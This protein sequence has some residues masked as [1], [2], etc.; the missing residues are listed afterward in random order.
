MMKSFYDSLEF[1][2]VTCEVSELTHT[3]V[4]KNL[5]EGVRVFND[6]QKLAHELATLNEMISLAER[7]GEL[8]LANSDNLTRVIS[9][10]EKFKILTVYDLEKVAQDVILIKHIQEYF[11]KVEADY[12]LLKKRFEEF[13][14]LSSLENL[15]HSV[16]SPNL[17]IYDT[18]SQE[19]NRIRRQLHNLEDELIVKARNIA[20][21]YSDYLQEQTATIRN[22]HYVL[23]VKAMYKFKVD[24]IIHDTSDSGNSVFIEPSLIVELNNKIASLKLEEQDEITRILRQLTDAVL[25]KKEQVITNNNILGYLDFVNAKT[26]F[27]LNHNAI[28]A[29]VSENRIIELKQAR[30]PL[31]DKQKVVANDFCLN[32]TQHIMIISGPNAG[33]K[34]V[35]LKTVGLLVVMHQ[36]GFPIPVVSAEIP[37]FKRIYVD[38][39]DQQSLNDSLSTFSAHMANIIDMCKK[40]GMKD[41]VLIDELGTG[42]DPNEGEALAKSMLDYLHFKHAY[43]LISSHFSGVKTYALDK[44]Y[45]INASMVF[46]EQNFAPT[47]RLRLGMPGKSYGMEVA[48]R[49][50]LEEQIILN[51]QKYLKK[52]GQNAFT[53]SLSKLESL[54]SDY[55]RKV[56]SINE[57]EKGLKEKEESLRKQEESLKKRH[58][59]FMQSV[60]EDKDEL[61]S[62]AQAQIDEIMRN[63]KHEDLKLHEIIK[64]RKDLEELSS[65]EQVKVDE[66]VN[67]EVNDYV[68][69]KDMNLIGKIIRTKGDKYI[70]QTSLGNITAAKNELFLTRKP[71]EKNIKMTSVDRAI[72]S[73]SVPL[74]L[75]L[76][77]MHVEEALTILE[78]YLDD[79]VIKGYHQV[80]IIHGS[81]TGALRTAV[82]EYLR[83]QKF[84]ASFRLGGMGEGGVGATV[85]EIK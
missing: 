20:K 76:I 4:A 85:V 63:L 72:I 48:K 18:A 15:I 10:A 23:A 16:I 31:I 84:V 45:V 5:L 47:Y 33:G 77:G 13:Q 64:A 3:V 81:G 49:L 54:V 71:T 65:E 59:N 39:G 7:F 83:K 35:A 52:D 34:S 37:F 32:P 9:D 29:N 1:S 43:A 51:A 56:K 38:I 22:G 30:H 66:N 79:V 28:V 68:E 8:P 62:V 11:K 41:L 53:N 55:E 80:R 50:G 27:A 82:H 67:L 12:P 61:I 21:T 25:N 70:V 78:K 74:E 14:D 75:N 60:E 58:E 24:G 2:S 6:E 17:T 69:I 73:H 26:R 57:R 19:L 36:A 46:D 44:D 40:L 42:T